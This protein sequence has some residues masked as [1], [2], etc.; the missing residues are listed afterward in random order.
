MKYKESQNLIVLGVG[1]SSSIGQLREFQS[2]YGLTFP[3]LDDYNR[4][5]YHRFFGSG[6]PALLL[7][8]KSGEVA[9]TYNQSELSEAE[10]EN[11]LN[12]YI[13]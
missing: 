3:V 4:D 8:N 2:K 10:I 11:L 9:Y 6:I 5:V 1:V 7:I 13:F 12:S